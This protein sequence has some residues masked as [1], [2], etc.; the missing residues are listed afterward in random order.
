METRARA[1]KRARA[2]LVIAG[3]VGVVALAGCASLFRQPPLITNEFILEIPPGR[4]N[5]A[6][7]GAPALAVRFMQTAPRFE[8]EEFVYRVG[9]D[10]WEFDFYNRFAV[11]PSEMMTTVVRRGIRR[12]GLFSETAIPGLA[13]PG[14]YRLEGYTAELYGDFR[15]PRRPLAVV[16]MHFALFEPGASEPL[17][18]SE[19]HESAIL[20]KTSP[21]ALVHAWAL[22]SGRILDS[23]NTDLR[24]A[25]AA[26]RLPAQPPG[27]G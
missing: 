13:P 6:P 12:G 11:S 25:L 9:D 17:F 16:A 8:T 27:G 10:L 7:R 23:L 3:L 5:T 4:A 20:G 14:S 1:G 26:A 21:E 24:R 22:A 15:D 18:E 2:P 19:Y